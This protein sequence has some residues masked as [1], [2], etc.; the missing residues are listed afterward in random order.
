MKL[1]RAIEDR[2]PVSRKTYRKT[3]EQHEADCEWLIQQ[4]NQANRHNQR[5]A[6]KDGL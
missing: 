4:L 6:P 2:L 3:I 5:K 1:F